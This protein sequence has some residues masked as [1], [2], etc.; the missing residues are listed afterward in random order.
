MGFWKKVAFWKL[1]IKLLQQAG[2]LKSKIP[3]DQPKKEKP[4]NLA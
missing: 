1:V 2:V 3:E 4:E